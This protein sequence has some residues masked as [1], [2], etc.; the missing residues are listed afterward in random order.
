MK[1]GEHIP[2]TL[3]MLARVL[4][5]ALTARFPDRFPAPDATAF[6]SSLTG[7]GR[8]GGTGIGVAAD[9]P[10]VFPG[11]LVI[12]GGAFASLHCRAWISELFAVRP[13]GWDRRV[14]QQEWRMR[15]TRIAQRVWRNRPKVR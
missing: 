4:D 8:Q 12:A 10:I 5:Q 1:Q 15:W 9:D 6:G 3:L 2:L 13:V 14:P 7:R 11:W